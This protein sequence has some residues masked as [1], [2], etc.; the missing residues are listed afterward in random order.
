MFESYT[1]CSLHPPSDL[2]KASFP[3]AGVLYCIFFFHRRCERLLSE[4]EL[5]VQALANKRVE[6]VEIVGRPVVLMAKYYIFKTQATTTITV[7]SKLVQTDPQHQLTS[8]VGIDITSADLGSMWILK[9]F[10]MSLSIYI[11]YRHRKCV[12]SVQLLWL[13]R[14]NLMMVIKNECALKLTCWWQLFCMYGIMAL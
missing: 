5:V 8:L 6:I 4:F 1:R 13:W 3:G 7:D 9:T 12:L 10:W 11:M 14:S 2:W